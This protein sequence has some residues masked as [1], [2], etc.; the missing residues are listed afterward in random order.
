MNDFGKDFQKEENFSELDAVIVIVR[1]VDFN[2]AL[3]ISKLKRKGHA[4]LMNTEN[5]KPEEKQR[6]VD[7]I[8]GVVMASD[9]LI[10]RIYNNV[11]IATG[12]NIGIIEMPIDDIG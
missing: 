1:P 2:D 5:M 7:F 11:F 4:I 9:G 6:L 10:A 12:K 8:S 3:K